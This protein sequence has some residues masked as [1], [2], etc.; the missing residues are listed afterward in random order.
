MKSYN[1]DNIKK[2][3]KTTTL[4]IVLILGSVASVLLDYSSW[5]EATPVILIA[6]GLFPINK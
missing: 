2:G 5:S 6:L 3:W 1:F 4:A